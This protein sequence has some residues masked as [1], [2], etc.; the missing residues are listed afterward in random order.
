MTVR[1]QQVVALHK[2]EPT[3]TA[4]QIGKRLGCGDSYVRATA[5]RRNLN[6]PSAKLG[7]PRKTV[8]LATRMRD[9]ELRVA[10]LE[11]PHDC[12]Q[13][14]STMMARLE[15]T[16]DECSSKVAKSLREFGY[17]SCTTEM[18]RA[19][20]DA[21]LGGKREHDLPH[22]IIGMFAGRQFDEVEEARP[23]ALARMK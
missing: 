16:K 8:T 5:Y 13:G 9:L 4:P 23:G 17:P 3:L 22:G 19:V 20:L 12:P 10:A 2:A 21:W 6:I 15:M 11:N 7:A 1:W 18:V 14:R